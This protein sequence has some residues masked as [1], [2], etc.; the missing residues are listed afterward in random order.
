M[1]KRFCFALELLMILKNRTMQD[2]LR[3]VRVMKWGEWCIFA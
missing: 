1:G 2:F 3:F